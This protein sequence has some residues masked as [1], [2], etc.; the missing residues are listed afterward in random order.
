[1]EEVVGMMDKGYF[2]PRT[3]ILKWVNSLLQVAMLIHI[4]KHY[5]DWT[6]W[7]RS[8]LSSDY[9]CIISWV[10]STIESQLEGKSRV[11]FHLQFETSSTSVHES[12]N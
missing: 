2:V 10:G 11:W 9:G 3:E 7:I 1:M 5:K 8:R 4:V 12:G 6:T